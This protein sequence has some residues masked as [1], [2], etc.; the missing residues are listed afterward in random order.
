VWFGLKEV[1][2]DRKV[3][4]FGCKVVWFGWKVFWFG[5]KVV[6]ISWKWY[7]LDVKTNFHSQI[8][9]FQPQ[10]DFLQRTKSKGHKNKH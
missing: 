5:G 1:W 6:K 7:G 2:F 8:Y 3:V 4:W 10:R 9:G